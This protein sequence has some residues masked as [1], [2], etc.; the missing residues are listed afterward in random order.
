MDTPPHPPPY[1]RGLQASCT[2][3][4][5][6]LGSLR[7]ISTRT[8]LDVGVVLESLRSDAGLRGNPSPSDRASSGAPTIAVYRSRLPSEPLSDGVGLCLKPTSRLRADW[9]WLLYGY[10]LRIVWEKSLK[11][12]KSQ[13]AQE[14]KTGMIQK[15]LKLLDKN[16]VFLVFIEWW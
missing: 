8:D 2:L 10:F 5:P 15:R 4:S 7:L 9:H 14:L 11:A 6:V 13:K 16:A 3:L 12:T 1:P